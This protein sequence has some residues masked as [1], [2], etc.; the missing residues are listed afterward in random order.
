[1]DDMA[2]LLLA[3]GA[4][5]R[6][7][8]RDKLLE[9]VEGRPLLRRQAE[10]A[11]ATGARVYVT[12]PPGAEARR[13]ALEGLA[14]EVVEVAD[15]AAGMAASFRA[16]IA[17]LPAGCRAA[18]VVLADMPELGAEDFRR[19]FNAFRDDPEAP[20]LR[21]AGPDG[22]PG[23]PVLFPQRLFAELA[24]LHGDQ[25]ARTVLQ[26]HRDEIRPIPLPGQRALTDLDTPEAW[27]T[28]RNAQQ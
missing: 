6:M 1:M 28:W 5:S 18:L 12:L 24:R 23:H 11:L 7:R 25:G 13:A 14:V 19:F 17:A 20:I 26:A 2:L 15:A 3:A 27:E 4:S 9:P 8:G 16:G 10:A 21:G 22:Q